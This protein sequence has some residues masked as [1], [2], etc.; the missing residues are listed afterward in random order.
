M[1]DLD[2]IDPVDAIEVAKILVGH[3][4]SPFE[5]FRVAEKEEVGSKVNHKTVVYVDIDGE[6]Y[7]TVDASDMSLWKRKPL[8]SRIFKAFSLLILRGYDIST[9]K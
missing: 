7:E 6:R 1:K 5:T 3:T 2:N 4:G 9:I 8:A